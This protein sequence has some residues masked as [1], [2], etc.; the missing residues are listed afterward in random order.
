[1]ILIIEC[2]SAKDLGS[3]IEFL[4]FNILLTILAYSKSTK[5]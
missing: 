2:L 1:M 4:Q 3:L 5:P